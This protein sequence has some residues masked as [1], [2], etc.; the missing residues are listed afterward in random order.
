MCAVTSIVDRSVRSI[1][2]ID[3]RYGGCWRRSSPKPPSHKPRRRLNSS[4]TPG[5]VDCARAVWRKRYPGCLSVPL[6][7][8]SPAPPPPPTIP[9][10]PPRP[11]SPGTTMLGQSPL[12]RARCGGG[13][14]R[15]LARSRARC[16]AVAMAFGYTARH[17]R[18]ARRASR[19]L[20]AH[21]IAAHRARRHRFPFPLHARMRALRAATALARSL[22]RSLR[23]RAV[24]R[25]RWR[26]RSVT[27]RVTRV[28]RARVHVIAAHRARH[29]R[30]PS[31]DVTHTRAR[32]RRRRCLVC[33]LARARGGGGG[34]VGGGGRLHRASR[35]SNT[36]RAP[37]VTRAYAHIITAS[38]ASSPFSVPPAHDR[39]ARAAAA[40]A[41]A[42][43]L[44]REDGRGGHSWRSRA[45]RSFR[46]DRDALT[47]RHPGVTPSCTATRGG[48]PFSALAR[49]LAS[50]KRAAGPSPYAPFPMVT[51]VLHHARAGIPACGASSRFPRHDR[52]PR[53][54]LPGTRVVVPRSLEREAVGIARHGRVIPVTDRVRSSR[55]RTR[56]RHHRSRARHHR[57]PSPPRT[58]GT[59]ALL[60]RRA[61]LSW[62][63]KSS[64][65][66]RSP[67]RC[68]RSLARSRA[69]GVA[70]AVE[71][72]FSY[73]ARHARASRTSRAR[74]CTSSPRIARVITAPLPRCHPCAR[75][76]AAAALSRLLAR[77]RARRR[78][79][80]GWGRRSVTSRVT[81]VKHVTR[82][83]RHARARAYHHRFARVI[84][85]FR[86]PRARP[87]RAR[88]CGGGARSLARARAVAWR[89]RWRWRSVTPR[90]TRVTRARVYVITAHRARHHRPPSPMSPMRA[91]GSG[92]GAVSFARFLAR[93]EAEADGH[94][95]VVR[96]S[97]VTR[98]R[99]RVIIVTALVSA[100]P[101]EVRSFRR[102]LVFSSL[103]SLV[104][105]FFVSPRAHYDE[106]T[107][108]M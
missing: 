34:G 97:R 72:A 100:T 24:W 20:H 26:W 17:A 11:S 38:R 32:Q 19:A 13:G 78:R 46:Y 35:V 101:I 79:R 51:P 30:P 54:T 27:S 60:R 69:C 106:T 10:K 49:E 80:W 52:T 86:P 25:W 92:G 18:Y 90:I 36:S 93:V 56:I 82:V 95:H 1:E 75:A 98:A 29:H 58:T 63:H 6:P 45:V 41:L 77:S 48:V 23:A 57:F 70:L 16:V 44:A 96:V 105:S 22:A 21:V 73:I 71:V 3:G 31:P 59:R 5:P 83:A 28:T 76:A 37:L 68:Y 2:S 107:G 85:V 87:A 74:A 61:V 12:T 64:W 108:D 99:A 39:H 50:R 102:R 55:A 66:G 94:S 9:S 53:L 8:K 33:S 88:C 47:A 62:F 14:A 40:A 42:R 89:W 84:T 91:R 43:S 104:F 103:F 81:R 65:E 7:P 15:S 67:K 4:S